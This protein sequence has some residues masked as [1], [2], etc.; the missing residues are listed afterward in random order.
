MRQRGRVKLSEYIITL[1]V[2]ITLNFILPRMMPGDPFLFLSADQGQDVMYT[3]EQRQQYLEFYGLNEPVGKQYLSY[4]GNLIRGNMG[5]SLYYNEPV[6]NIIF[7]RLIWTFFLVIAAVLF[8]TFIGMLLGSISAWFREK[9]IDKFLFFSL[10]IFSEIPSFLLGLILLFIFAADLNL[11]PLSG[12]MSY[13]KDFSSFWVK[14][15]DILHHAALPVIALS[16][17]RLGGS[18]L[19]GR[20]SVTSVLEKDY[21]RTARAKG[22][23]KIRII[24][25]YVIRNALLPVVTRMFLSLG[26]LVGGAI[27]V[28]NVFAYPGLGQLMRQSVMVRDYPLIQGIFLV[29]SIF[30]L[31]ANQLADFVYKIID[32]RISYSHKSKLKFKKVGD[33]NEVNT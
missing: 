15:V 30:V 16:V 4:L 24:F 27:L 2:I 21:I 20:N 11:F 5:Y 26:S 18:Y 23:S 12:A 29:V 32:P 13:F 6:V 22:L 33:Q 7:R 14:V 17:A 1:L 9:W 25:N 8:S 19:L 3:E 10:I 28:E 31:T